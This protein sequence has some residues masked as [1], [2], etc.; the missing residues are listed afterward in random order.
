M[1]QTQ[2]KPGCV[3]VPHDARIAGKKVYNV[4]EV[5]DFPP[6]QCLYQRVWC[7]YIYI[8]THACHKFNKI[9]V[10]ITSVSLLV[11]IATTI[12]IGNFCRRQMIVVVIYTQKHASTFTH[13]KYNWW[14]F[15]WS[16]RSHIARDGWSVAITY[17]MCACVCMRVYI[18]VCSQSACFFLIIYIYIYINVCTYVYTLSLY[19]SVCLKRSSNLSQHMC[20]REHVVCLQFAYLI[21]CIHIYVLYLLLS[22]VAA[23]H[24]YICIYMQVHAKRVR[25]PVYI[26]WRVHT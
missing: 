17:S 9:L 16:V 25:A 13:T 24:G 21:I 19:F 5:C 2:E 3:F 14:N 20:V 12:I 23:L 26:S 10:N 18:Y 4:H 8:H 6:W 1:S 22:M 15:W 11:N 7:I